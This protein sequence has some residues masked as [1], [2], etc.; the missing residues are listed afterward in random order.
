M[1]FTFGVCYY[2]EHWPENRWAEDAQWMRALGFDV[3][4]LAEFAWGKMEPTPGNFNFAWLD[5]AI[6]IFSAHG[7]NIVLGTP[8]AAPPAWLSRQYPDT[9]PVDE[10]GRRRNFGG[11]RHYCPSHPT[12]RELSLRIV[13]EMGKRYGKDPRIIGWQIDNE[14]GGSGTARCYCPACALAFREWL[15]KRYTQLDS[16]NEAWGNVFWSQ[17]YTDWSQIEPPILT[18][19][20]ANPSHILEY[21]RFASE[22]MVAFQQIQVDALR[23]L[24]PNQWVTHNFMG[25][26]PDLNYFDLAKP[27]TFVT[28]DSYP[29]GNAD[30]WRDM[31]YGPGHEP[32]K[33]APDVGD[34]LITGFAHDLTRGLLNKPFWIMEQQVGH[35]NWGAY[36][37]AIRPGVPRLWVWHA[38]AHGANGII[39]F[40]ERATLYAQEQY[41][42]GLLKHDGTPDLGYREAE[43]LQHER[44]RLEDIA[45]QPSQAAVA[46][47]WN[48]DDL[49]AL[50]LQPQHKEFSYTRLAFTF[51]AALRQ[52]G[53]DVDIVSPQADLSR[54]ALVICPSAHV[55][56][57]TLARALTTYTENGGTVLFGVRSGFKTRSNRVTHHPLPG[58][59][60]DLVGALVS[61]WHALAPGTSY[62]VKQSDQPNSPGVSVSLWAEGLTPTT[63]KARAVYT[64]GPFAGKAA[65]TD[66]PVG[67]G[68]ALYCGWYPTLDQATQIVR[69]LLQALHLRPIVDALPSGLCALRRGPYTLL[70]NFSDQFITAI[71]NGRPADVSPR[72][73]L[74]L[75]NK[76]SS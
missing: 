71:V 30:R 74:L 7:L 3:V 45:Q 13:R 20:K 8:T 59:F 23:T 6:D 38:V 33:Y 11:R 54:Y 61:E 43:H 19:N 24:A 17:T 4:R 72:D 36:N 18:L 67:R 66:N 27:L 58:V 65:F 62:L 55:A 5:K 70:F 39:Y 41:H 51:Y 52:L 50:Q 46:L 35:I 1:P 64:S 73:V 60:R 49:W 28:W 14:F 48:Y 10:Q 31:L 15:K 21:W 68:R 32:V 69:P 53:Y 16:L 44:A 42:S 37:Q 76:N 47:M 56:D 57:F 63:G 75:D 34:P 40:R 9:L 29:T 12:Y 25:L 22:V 26:F 2:P